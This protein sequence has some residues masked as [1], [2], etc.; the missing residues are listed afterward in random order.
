MKVRTDNKLKLL[1]YLRK[2]RNDPCFLKDFDLRNTMFCGYLRKVTSSAR[3]ILLVFYVIK[4]Y[5]EIK[6]KIKADSNDKSIVP[7]IVFI[8]G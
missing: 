6:A 5:I 8:G 3:H 7:R 1:H 2:E 4:R